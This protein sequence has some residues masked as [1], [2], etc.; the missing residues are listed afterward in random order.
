MITIG[1]YVAYG[2][3][4]HLVWSPHHKTGDFWAYP[5][6]N[7]NNRSWWIWYLA[8]AT[9]FVILFMAVVFLHKLRNKFTRR[10]NIKSDT[11][12]NLEEDWDD[13]IEKVD[14]E[15]EKRSCSP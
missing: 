8:I 4:Q 6:L 9:G 14:I 1:L 13:K 11:V 10:S 7:T 15:K 12:E 5:F 2:H 3:F